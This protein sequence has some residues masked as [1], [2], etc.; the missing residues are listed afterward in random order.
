MTEI[1]EHQNKLEVRNLTR[2]LRANGTSKAIVDGVSYTFECGD[3]YTI[4]GPSGA[5]KS[6]LLRLLNRLDEPTEG[7]V[8]FDGR[9]YREFPV[10]QLRLRIGYL[11][12][13]PYLFPGTIAENIR[14]AAAALSDDDVCDLLKQTGLAG[15]DCGE[16]VDT[17]SGGEKQ[18]VALARLLATNPSVLLLDEPTSALD[19]TATR[20]IEELIWEIVARACYTVVMVTHEPAQA[21][22]MA[23][24]TLLMAR[25]KLI[26]SGPTEEVINNPKSDEGRRYRDREL[27]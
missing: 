7:E 8:W 18:R 15:K 4:V 24:Q 23:G 1:S 26:E 25:G 20:G 21:I 19:P 11:F 16:S 12:Q 10:R 13:Q 9:D 22:R 5:G 2:T 3:I 17:L 6:S 27:T 14:F